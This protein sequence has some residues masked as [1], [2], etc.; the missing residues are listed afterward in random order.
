M[1]GVDWEYF[2]LYQRELKDELWEIKK[3]LAALENERNPHACWYWLGNEWRLG[4]LRPDN[5]PVERWHEGYMVADAI[6]GT[7]IHV[8]LGHVRR[9]DKPTEP[10]QE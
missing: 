9:G 6:H 2:N 4:Y 5:I 1:S 10:P 3:R 7:I 8:P